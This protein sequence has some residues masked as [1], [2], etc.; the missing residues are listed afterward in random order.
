MCHDTMGQDG[1]PEQD[2]VNSSQSDMDIR[3]IFLMK[4]QFCPW[5]QYKKGFVQKEK[6]KKVKRSHN[7]TS[8]EPLK[9]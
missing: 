6:K 8:T 5:L 4:W 2:F 1:Y 7:N 9:L 3:E